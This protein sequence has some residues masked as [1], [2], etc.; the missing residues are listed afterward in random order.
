MLAYIRS[1]FGRIAN[2]NDEV[3]GK[4]EEVFQ[5]ILE[6]AEGEQR[7][8]VEFGEPEL[9]DRGGDFSNDYATRIP[10]STQDG[11]PEPP[12]I[13]YELPD[14]DMEEEDSA[15]FKLLEL[16]DIE[17]VSALGELEGK[18]VWGTFEDG[19]LSLRFDELQDE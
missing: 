6:N 10:T 1:L 17:T 2:T 4:S 8:L 16:Y 11:D 13:E 5:A 7:Y 15:L 12:N 3:V 19:T 18:S 9:I 14:S